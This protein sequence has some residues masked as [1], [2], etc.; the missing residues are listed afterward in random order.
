MCDMWRWGETG[1]VLCN[2]ADA[3]AKGCYVPLGVAT[4]GMWVFEPPWAAYLEPTF[5]TPWVS[6]MF[7]MR[8]K[9]DG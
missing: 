6:K 7:L 1:L 3:Y 8:R 4:A 9:E 2:E 5:C